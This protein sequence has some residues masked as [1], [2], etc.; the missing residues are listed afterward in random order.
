MADK[1]IDDGLQ[2]K[3]APETGFFHNQCLVICPSDKKS[4][5]PLDVALGIVYNIIINDNKYHVEKGEYTYE[6]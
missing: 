2:K 6:L 4:S 3:A 5:T 1:P